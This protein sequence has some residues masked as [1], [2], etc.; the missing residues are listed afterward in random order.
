MIS[1][2][3][4][5]WNNQYLWNTGT[6]FGSPFDFSTGNIWSMPTFG[7]APSSKNDTV[8]ENKYMIKSTDANNP[9][10]V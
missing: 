5:D 6:S 4:N 2:I 10:L 9:Q 1:G 3:N 8:D 7:S